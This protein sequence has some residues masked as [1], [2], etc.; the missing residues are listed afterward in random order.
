MA[1]YEV[2]VYI[3]YQVISTITVTDVDSREEA[4]RIALRKAASTPMI[5]ACMAQEDLREPFAVQI[6]EK[7]EG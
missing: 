2:E 4:E 7:R 6:V 3:S 5:E 1:T